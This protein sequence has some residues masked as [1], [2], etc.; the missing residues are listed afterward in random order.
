M[1]SG[2][3][4][5]L[6]IA[7][8]GVNHDGNLAQAVAL[9]RAA[10]RAGADVV[11]FQHFR[12]DALVANGTATAKYQA[13]NTAETDQSAMLRRL[14]LSIEDFQQVAAVCHEEGIEF[15]CTP[16][17]AAAIGNL[18]KLGMQWLKVPSGELTNLPLLREFARQQLPI[19]LSTGMATLDEVGAAVSTLDAAGAKAI[20][21]LQCTSIYPAPPET[22]NLRAMVTMRERFGRPVGFSDHSADDHAAIAAVALG[23]CVIEK[24]FTLDRHLPG[25]DHGASLEPDAFAHMV[26]R[27]RETLRALGDGDK[28]PAEEERDFATLVRR[29]WHAARNLAA[30][31]LIAEN[32]AVL[33]RPADG[34]APDFQLVGRRLVRARAADAP[35]RAG[36]LA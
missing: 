23:A 18:V 14:E 7:E 9:V 19:L 33:K 21:L 22:L 12:S 26:R 11:K 29:S 17:D 27:L 4:N 28:R 34:L 1:A 30:G 8:A 24:H 25:P 20:T 35:I 32:D 13:A 2:N 15:L 3:D 31:E 36:D 6:I 16:F 5:L 10:K